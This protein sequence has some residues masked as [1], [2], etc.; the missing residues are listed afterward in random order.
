MFKEV[1]RDTMG[2]LFDP[3]YNNETPEQKKARVEQAKKSNSKSRTR[4][5]IL[6][7]LA[8]ITAV[9]Y[10]KCSAIQN[11]LPGL[12][13]TPSTT[14]TAQSSESQT[15]ASQITGETSQTSVSETKE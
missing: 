9:L 8:V 12:G 11:I 3:N 15:E 6:L 13:I 7:L 1:F 4:T 10:D 5:L 14:T 2:S